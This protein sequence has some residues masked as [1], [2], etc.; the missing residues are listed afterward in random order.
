MYGYLSDDYTWVSVELRTEPPLI[1]KSSAVNSL[2]MQ[3]AK[4][5]TS[6]ISQGAGGEDQVEDGAPR[7]KLNPCYLNAWSHLEDIESYFKPA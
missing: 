2:I 3:K 5:V 6:I 1:Q 7:K 4:S